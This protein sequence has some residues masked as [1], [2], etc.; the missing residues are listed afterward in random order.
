MKSRNLLKLIIGVNLVAIVIAIPLI[1]GCAAPAVPT[2]TPGE[3][4]PTP[5]EPTPTPEP[6]EEM[7]T[8]NLRFQGICTAVNM[9]NYLSQWIKDIEQGTG[10]AITIDLYSSSELVDD[11][12]ILAAVRE[13]TLD[14][15]WGSGG[16]NP[17][18]TP[19]GYVEVSLPY[20][21]VNPTEFN[22][23]FYERGIKEL[24]EEGY[25]EFGVHYVG[26]LHTDP[27]STLVTTR[28][29]E[30]YED[31]QGLKISSWPAI[32]A[33][34]FKAGAE[35]SNIDPEE[36]FLAGETGLLDGIGWG[37]AT[38]YH[39]L[40]LFEVFEY[41]L[42]NSTMGA[43]VD[44]IVFN[45]EVWDEL[46]PAYQKVIELAT[47]RAS[48]H[49]AWWLYGGESSLR[50]NWTVTRLSAEDEYKL[51]QHAWEYWDELA[52]MNPQAAQV[53]EIYKQYN[54][55]T[56]RNLWHRTGRELPWD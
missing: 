56:E 29:I 14:C 4:T 33:P 41:Y 38:T 19:T 32:A 54:S 49:A 10:G 6:A 51:M 23:L 39:G 35:V 22:V 5:G 52:A 24:V 40:G 44:N 27:V 30:K 11:E 31:F 13:G 55:E 16:V 9:Q 1:N 34:W 36:F 47:V 43:I 25:A 42:S 53:V 8:W 7:P 28:P 21:V 20:G 50:D 46:P 2:P 15:G 12:S 17:T 3:P 18:A 37:G 26:P 48:W 45:Q